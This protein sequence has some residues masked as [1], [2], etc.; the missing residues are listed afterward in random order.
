MTCYIYDFLVVCVSFMYIKKD[1]YALL[2][3]DVYSGF[4]QYIT[5]ITYV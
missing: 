1:N 4:F 5:C 2:H 3:D